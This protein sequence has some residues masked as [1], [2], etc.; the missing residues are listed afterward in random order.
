MKRAKPAIEY[1]VHE[2]G[3]GWTELNAFVELNPGLLRVISY[4]KTLTT[5]AE[6]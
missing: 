2:N 3:T 5:D 1:E 6:N 4:E